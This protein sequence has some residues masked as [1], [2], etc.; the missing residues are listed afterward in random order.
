MTT[1]RSPSATS[2][3]YG[4]SEETWDGAARIH[5]QVLSVARSTNDAGRIA[6]SLSNLAKSRW[7]AGN[8]DEARTLADEAVGLCRKNGDST[9]LANALSGSVDIRLAAGDLTGARLD[10]EEALSLRQQSGAAEGMAEA[11]LSLANLNM[12]EGNGAAA[13]A[14][15]RQVLPE[16]EN[17]KAKSDILLARIAL[18][19]A[20]LMQGKVTESEKAA[21]DAASASVGSTDPTRSMPLAILQASLLAAEAGSGATRQERLR[22]ARKQLQL[23]VAQ[24]RKIRFY[25]GECRGRLALGKV[26]MEAD[27]AL[28]RSTLASLEESASSHG[29]LLIAHQAALG[30]D[31]RTVTASTRTP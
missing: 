23:V 4:P 17:Q 27:A 8:P 1:T 7:I 6:E 14:M 10:Y 18:G 29:F 25:D 31:S 5:E 19:N 20:L 11:R 13:E 22:Q 28:G 2:P 26:E 24:A 12:A 16:F 15:L 21:D 30:R 3:T 9:I